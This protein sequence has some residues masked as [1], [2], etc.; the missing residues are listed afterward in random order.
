MN[1][2]ENFI[3]R[4]S[5]TI[6]SIIGA[7]G[8]IITS[9]LTIKATIKA[10]NLYNSREDKETLTKKDIVKTYWKEYIPSILSGSITIGC[11]FGSNYINQ[12]TKA[13]L[14]SAYCLLQ[15][16]YIEYK[17]A[18]NELYDGADNKIRNKICENKYN[19][20][21]IIYDEN[22][23]LFYDTLSGTFIESTMD[24]MLKHESEFLELLYTRGKVTVNQWERIIGNEQSI[25]GNELVWYSNDY[26]DVQAYPEVQIEITPDKLSNGIKVNM[27]TFTIDPELDSMV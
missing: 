19:E 4:N 23:T 1:K 3:S 15:N 14:V 10:N 22:T 21:A 2:F 9:G 11:I 8:V 27:I 12:K 17:N 18:A 20:N 25:I 5:P 6:L 24:E 7:T 26:H 13:T 16:S